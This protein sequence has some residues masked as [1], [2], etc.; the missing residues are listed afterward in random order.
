MII[1]VRIPAAL[2][3][4]ILS[5]TI[6]LS[7]V[8]LS[9][10]QAIARRPVGADQQ[11]SSDES[12]ESQLEQLKSFLK[13]N[14]IAAN[15]DGIRNYL[16]ELN[17]PTNTNAAAKRL[18]K[19]LASKD[20]GVREKA[21]NSLKR[22]AIP[23]VN[24]LQKA[25]QDPDF[26]RAYRAQRILI[27]MG[28]HQKKAASNVLLAIGLLKIDG[29]TKE[30]FETVSR[31]PKDQ[32]VIRSAKSAMSEVQSK[33]K[34]FLVAQMTLSKPSSV[35]QVAVYCLRQLKDS[36]LVDRFVSWAR[37]PQFA[38][39]TRLE[40]MLALA[41]LGNRHSL[42]LLVTLMVEADDLV[43]RFRCNKAL[44]SLT[45]QNFNFRSYYNTS[46][47][48]TKAKLW[49]DWIATN[50]KTATLKFPL[51]P[52]TSGLEIQRASLDG[53][54]EKLL[55][56]IEVPTDKATYGQFNDYGPYTGSSWKGYKR[57]PPGIWV[58][59]APNWYIWE[60]PSN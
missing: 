21:Q 6:G 22:M 59:V 31:F 51:P 41:D 60:R 53:K 54:Y 23:P 7:T 13:E 30:V 48:A 33:D 25:S 57:I 10:Q 45:G 43:V 32:D 52:K 16:D 2:S 50:G 36:S 1:L 12:S 56:I 37:Y 26:E 3:T 15:R 19:D 24:K 39:A 28:Q 47:R 44:H 20:F 55:A 27:K 38:D 4:W 14:S 34:D 11:S 35:R 42:S 40:A 17:N 29:L 18:I 46:E 8:P 9:A 5:L 49:E 58:Y